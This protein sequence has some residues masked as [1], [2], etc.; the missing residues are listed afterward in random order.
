MTDKPLFEGIETSIDNPIIIT[1]SEPMPIATSTY[2]HTPMGLIQMA[3]ERG[4]ALDKLEKLM[5]LQ[6]RW[7]ASEARKA[8][9]RAFA[10]FKAESVQIVKNITVTDGPLKG[11]RYADLFAVVDSI[12]PALSK[13]GLSCSWKLSKDDPTWME[14]TCYLKHEDGHCETAFMGGPPDSGGAKSAIQ[15]RASSKSYLERYTILAITG[16]AATDQD[17]DG[18][19]P[20]PVGLPE[21]VFLGHLAAI[22][23]AE[24]M[25]ALKPIFEKA[26]KSAG[27]DQP[28]KKA[29][30]VAYDKRKGELRGAK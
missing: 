7:E 13:H 12:T 28:T 25:D 4:D 30:Q 20:A 10:A 21:D 11:K 5:D 8:F 3:V 16:L 18:R 14:V 29:L 26:W 23:G 2:T 24:T 1:K 15:A 17:N 19:G 6:E 9:N 27:L 22:R